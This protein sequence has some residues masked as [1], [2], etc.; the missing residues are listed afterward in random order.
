MSLPARILF[1]ALLLLVSALPGARPV[2]A[3][4]IIAPSG[5]ALSI[6]AG[7]GTLLRLE[8]PAST[9]FVA[10]PSVADVQ[11]KSQRLIYVFGKR[12]G[13]TTFYAVDGND[14]VIDSR[15]LSVTHNVSRVSDAVQR[16]SGENPIRIESVEGALVIEG[17]VNSANKA[18]DISMLAR[19]LL[20]ENQPLIERVGVTGP[21]QVNL[22]VRVAEMSR[23]VTKQ[24]GLNG[25]IV[26]DLGDS[27]IGLATGQAPGAGDA[28]N[29]RV[30]GVSN[31]FTSLALGA[32][33]INAVLDALETNGL[34]TTLAEPNLTARSGE[35]ASFLAGG[36][37]PIL[38]P[39]GDGSISITFKKFGVSLAFTPTVLED[40]RISLHVRPEVSQLSQAGAIEL[41]GFV[42]PALT[43]RRAETTVD[44][45]SGQSFAIA[46]LLESDVTQDVNKFPGL[47]E[48]PIL[49]ALFRS[50]E[51]RRFESELVIIVTPY[52][53]RPVSPTRLAT[54]VDGFG[55]PSDVDRLL[56]RPGPVGGIPVAAAGRPRLIGP[57]GFRI[58]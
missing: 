55:A 9:V 19:S 14:Q 1:I 20:P 48:L 15:Q 57:A 2:S 37:F 10:D 23:D 54:P 7:G 39:Q 24:F 31:L 58:E 11:V 52:L 13:S 22:R 45:A 44:L 17:E 47:A 40:G 49:G 18:R 32:V 8:R 50:D 56:G 35:T 6:E 34:S 38:V 53:V 41:A 21:R 4:E 46:G 16:I 42:V 5:E 51:F 3:T 28:L 27:T 29:L 12:P 25:D 36:E 30:G 43:T 26:G 33:D